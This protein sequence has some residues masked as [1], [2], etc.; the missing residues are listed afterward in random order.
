MSP[1]GSA[2]APPAIAIAGLTRRFG[3]FV[4]V[5]DVTFAVGRGEVFGLIGANGAGKSTIIKMLTTL[6]PPSA[7][8]IRID[9]IDAIRRPAE[10]RRRIGYVPQLLSADGSLT[11]HENLLLSARLYGVPRAEV[12]GRITAALANMELTPF[13]DHLVQSY[14]GGMIRRLEVAQSMLH[15]PTVLFMDEPTVGLDPIARRTVIGHVGQLR[16]TFGT[17]IVITSHY[18]EELEEICDRLAVLSHGRLVALD[19]P[20]A[21]K[22]RVGPHATLDDV[23]VALSGAPEEEETGGLRATRLARRAARS[24]G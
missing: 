11:G 20:T 7:G 16:D 21:L 6:L 12:R 5:D 10:V 1:E 4:A 22:A 13:A 9:G 2:D 18:M 8:S 17:T 24:H 23:F 3:D 14:S 19:T 15:H